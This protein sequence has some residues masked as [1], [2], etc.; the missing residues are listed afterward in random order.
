[1]RYCKL[2][3]DT[4][5]YAIAQSMPNLYSIDL[6]F[7]TNITI[8]ALVRILEIRGRSLSELRLQACRN[9][10]IALDMHAFGP[11]AH[12]HGGYAGR[13]ILAALRSHADRC[14][15]SILDVRQCGGQ[16]SMRDAYR[17][18]DPFVVGMAA[19]SF[20]QKVPGFFG[21]PAQWNPEIKRN[22]INFIWS[23]T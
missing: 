22:L 20:E 1:M 5:V 8:S 19:L 7:C 3:S 11:R 16:P 10:E 23:S 9:L 2:I 4:G 6:S 17:E 21:R 12:N 13:Q 15:L 18:T 14:C